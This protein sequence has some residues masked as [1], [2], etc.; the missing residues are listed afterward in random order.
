DIDCHVIKPSVREYDDCCHEFC[1]KTP[2]V[3]KGLCRKEI[4][5]AIDLFNQIV[6]HE[7]LRMI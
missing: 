3:F 6:R 4:L 5:F 7:L 2:Y 1:N